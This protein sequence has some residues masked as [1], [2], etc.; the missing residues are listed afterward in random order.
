MQVQPMETDNTEGRYADEGEEVFGL[1]LVATVEP[2]A[3]GQP[4]HGPLDHPPV[5][6]EPL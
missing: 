4:G 2:S 3:S 5:T 6:A 1:A